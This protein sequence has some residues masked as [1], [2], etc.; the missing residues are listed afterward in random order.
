MQRIEGLEDGKYYIGRCILNDKQKEIAYNNP[1]C[2]EYFCN[3]K[4][5]VECT[6]C[7]KYL[8]N[9]KKIKL[10]NEDFFEQKLDLKND[11]KEDIKTCKKKCN[12]GYI[13]NHIERNEEKNNKFEIDNY[14]LMDM[15]KNN[16][17]ITKYSD[18]P[19]LINYENTFPKP[20]TVVHWGQLKMLLIT[21]LFLIKVVDPD[22][23]E[24]HIIYAGSARGDNILLLAEMFPNTIWYL[25][26][27]RPHNKKLYTKLNNKDQIHEILK[28]YFTD[29]IAK[30]YSEKFK[31]RNHK[32]LFL[33]DIREGT[34]DEKVLANQESNANW[35]RIIQPD[36]S[37]LKFRC[38]YESDKIYK[39]YKGEI[40]L[41]VYAPASST[42]ARIL[43]KK[44]LEDY[45]YNIDEYQGKMLYFNR[46]IRPSYHKTLFKENYYFDHCYDCTYFSYIIKNYLSKF[47]NVNPFSNQKHK[48]STNN[49]KSKDIFSIMKYIT[50]Y[51]CKHSQDKIKSHNNYVRNNIIQ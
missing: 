42:E 15:F 47:S 50:N 16:D 19:Y 33:S 48:G 1:H 8:L 18:L 7:V 36:F 5:I 45:E 39:Y 9:N 41:Q 3:Y 46:V 23:K 12:N 6:D 27:P 4:N 37:Y 35:H 10:F 25:V 26:D 20:K 24:V 22:E 11:T 17:F 30:R 21:I 31:N 43:F 2:T 32:L 51:L 29:D 38:G 44:E 34:E 49:K 40:Y 28:E 14:K 13:Y